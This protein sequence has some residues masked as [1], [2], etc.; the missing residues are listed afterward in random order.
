MAKNT[1]AQEGRVLI[2]VI[3]FMF[4]LSAFWIIALTMTGSELSFVGGRKTASQQFYDAEAGAAWVIDNF[5][6][7]I[8]TTPTS[9]PV[10]N[11]TVAD[12]GKTVAQVTV[13]PIKND[14]TYASSN[15]LP[16]QEHVFTGEGCNEGNGFG[17][18]ECR[19]Y[20]ITATAGGKQILV[21][22]YRR[23]IP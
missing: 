10:R 22:V 8:P 3:I 5:S 14:A 11:V 4:T 18:V 15:S 19:R 17:T 2:M 13:R 20:A 23:V 21:G 9:A 16:Q 1:S 12:G 6:A 7:N